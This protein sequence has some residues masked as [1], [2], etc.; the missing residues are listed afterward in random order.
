MRERQRGRQEDRAREKVRAEGGAIRDKQIHW[1]GGGER[2][3]E[4]GERRGESECV[5]VCVCVCVYLCV[6]CVLTLPR[7]G[8]GL[9][10][11]LL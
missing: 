3:T 4:R 1:Q 5:C 10:Q 8:G 9:G 11:P 6:V 2:E 7:G